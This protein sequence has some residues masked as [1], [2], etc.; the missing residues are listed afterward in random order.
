MTLLV[1]SIAAN[2]LATVRYLAERAWRS[3]CDAVELR[4][5]EYNDE[6]ESL[7]DY[8]R[9]N[10]DHTWIVTCRSVE[11]G[12]RCDDDAATRAALL[13]SVAEGSGAYV[14]FELR[15]WEGQPAAQTDV[16]AAS[17]VPGDG[18]SRLIL[19]AH[20][21]D[22]PFDELAHVLQTARTVSQAGSIKLAYRARHICDSFE[23]LDLL[24]RDQDRRARK[25]AGSSSGP[26]TAPLAVM[27]MDDHGL[28]TRVLAKKF[29][30]F[31]SYCSLERG[32][33]TAPGQL[34][35]AEMIHRYRWPDIDAATKIYGVIGDPVAQS[36]SPFLHNTW[37]AG[38][39]AVY[40]PLR[41]AGG[42]AGLT[43]F[44]DGCRN[45][46]WLDLAGLSVTTPH[47]QSALDW[48]GGGADSMSRCIGAANTL[49]F[50]SDG[51]QGYNTDAYASVSSLVAALDCSRA[52][53]SRLPIDILGVGGAARAVAH[54]L[55]EYGCRL[56]FYGRSPEKTNGLAEDHHGVAR[57]WDERSHRSGEV[58][59]NCTSVGMWP[60]VAASP[61]PASCFNGCTLAY[62]LIY[63][64][65]AT[66]F[67]AEAKA[68]GCK[69]LNGLDMF[70]RQAAMQFELW[71]GQR[72][73]TESACALLE[74]EVL[75]Q[76]QLG[77]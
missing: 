39:N 17:T 59:I 3:G 53:L 12:G 19:S 25:T 37:L 43:R 57:S 44:L 64:P 24:R 9:A 47:K 52:N 61:L 35:V 32:A 41:V 58:V 8:L 77:L 30:A 46:P 76:V 33:A 11:E 4:I 18:P 73:D 50:S 49:A 21:F 60:D 70:V 27:A 45:R 74:R 54:G 26:S 48:L 16:V 69:T 7:R 15:D 67:L 29:G 20:D 62:D 55:H 6:P 31:A 14:D 63:N 13:R 1:T 56:T 34:T 40:L 51:T 75:E 2:N 72:P 65:L 28:W 42:S 38:V 66:R 23:A 68:A 10:R 5:D 71:T 22:G 36:M